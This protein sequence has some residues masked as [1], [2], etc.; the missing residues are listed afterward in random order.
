MPRRAVTARLDSLRE[1]ST[2][3]YHRRT[4]RLETAM[5]APTQSHASA[6]ATEQNTPER[7]SARRYRCC[8]ECSVRPENA[9]GVGQWKGIVYNIST[10]GVGMALSCPVSAGTVLLIEPWRWG[11]GPSPR[12]RR[13]LRSR[14]LSL[15]SRVRV[16]RTTFG[17]CAGRAAEV[18]LR[19]SHWC[20]LSH[21]LQIWI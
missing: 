12:T 16:R 3:V 5:F 21:G 14:I 18:I 1:T 6:G 19:L 13:P 15:L 9:A 17:R 10:T 4:R 2:F 7:R 20:L 11:Q 8:A